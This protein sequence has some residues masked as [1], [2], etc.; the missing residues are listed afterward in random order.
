M[1]FAAAIPY[2]GVPI[3]YIGEVTAAEFEAS[4]AASSNAWRAAAQEYA[5]NLGKFVGTTAAGVAGSIMSKRTRTTMDYDQAQSALTVNHIGGPG[6]R[7]LCQ[8]VNIKRGRKKRR[9]SK[10]LKKIELAQKVMVSRF[11]SITEGFDGQYNLSRCLSYYIINGTSYFPVYAFNLTA[12]PRCKHNY[13]N[14]VVSAEGA[15]FY[16]LTKNS[17]NQYRWEKQYG[18]LNSTTGVDDRFQWN[19]E[20]RNDATDFPAVPDYTLDWVNARLMF[21]AADAVDSHIDIYEVSFLQKNGP[22]REFYNQDNWVVEDPPLTGDEEND[23]TAW[24]DHYLASRICHPFRTSM[25]R[26]GTIPKMWQIYRHKTITFGARTDSDN[27]KEV[28]NGVEFTGPGS[29]K[30]CL[31][32][33]MRYDADINLRSVNNYVTGQ[34]NNVVGTSVN[35]VPG[36]TT[37]N[38]NQQANMFQPPEKDRWLVISAKNYNKSTQN[39][40]VPDRHY[41]DCSFDMNI[42]QKVIYT[43]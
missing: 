32:M 31:N 29:Y 37:I 25:L 27:R 38:S 14:S 9:I 2:A 35:Q 15:P 43:D 39:D 12:F 11:Q 26:K 18:V 22:L 36:F 19:V 10:I 42:R 33:F 30:K 8:N 6:G 13:A 40:T 28:V 41:L 24:W 34:T 5:S 20:D 17:S 7:S 4:A 1:A 23:N 16:R 21:S 3:G